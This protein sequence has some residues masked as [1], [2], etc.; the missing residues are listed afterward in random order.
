MIH[1]FC[2]FLPFFSPIKPTPFGGLLKRVETIGD[3]LILLILAVF[4]PHK[5]Y[6]FWGIVGGLLKRGETVGDSV[7]FVFSKNRDSNWEN[8]GLMGVVVRPP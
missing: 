5:A 7:I 2:Q 4:F 6:P 3:L 1:L 8:G